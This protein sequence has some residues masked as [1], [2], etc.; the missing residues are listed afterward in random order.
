MRKIEIPSKAQFIKFEAENRAA[1]LEIIR[2]NRPK[3]KGHYCFITKYFP[4]YIPKSTQILIK[5][6]R[7]EEKAIRHFVE[8][9]KDYNPY[10]NSTLPVTV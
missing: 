7:S 8:K 3:Q 6:G 5:R 10:S 4:D 1:E 2:K 9:R